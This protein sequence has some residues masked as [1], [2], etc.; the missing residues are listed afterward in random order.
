[1]V[2]VLLSRPGKIPDI[3]ASNPLDLYYMPY[4]HSLTAS[5]LWSMAAV[6]VYRL[7]FRN[8]GWSNGLIVGM[9]VFS[10]WIL[11]FIVHR[12]DLPLYDN[13]HKV[14][15]G[16]WN[17]PLPALFAEAVFLFG[18]MAIYLKA[19][20]VGRPLGRYGMLAFGGIML[21]VQC[22]V[23]F[24]APPPSDKAAAIT[25]LI[26]YFLF[27]AIA[28]GLERTRKPRADMS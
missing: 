16:L 9:A 22:L 21:A 2:P 11:D 23:F 12:P 4:T 14:G 10:H 17:Y 7:F 6:L 13:A 20:Q 8:Q 3:T 26:S 25:A 18:G 19:T 1:M 27:A 5:L 28:Y 24:G 15:L